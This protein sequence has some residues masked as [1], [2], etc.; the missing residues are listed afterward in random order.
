MEKKAEITE[1]VSEEILT[2]VPKPEEI[3]TKD[4]AE[5]EETIAKSVAEIPPTTDELEKRKKKLVRLFKTK[6]NWIYGVILAFLV[7]IAVF[8]RTRNLPRLRDVSTGTWTL[9]P[10]LDPFL[11]LRWAKYI[12]ANGSLMIIDTMRYS[13]LGY[14]TGSEMKLLSYLIVW[15][16]DFLAFFSKEA[17]VTYAAVLFPVVMFAL[18][19]IA[20]FLFARKIFYKETQKVRNIIALIATCF[21]ILIPSLLPRTIAGIPEK[22]SAAFFFLFMAFY[23]FLEAMTSKKMKTSVIWAILAGISTA[24]MALVWGG[25]IFVFFTIPTAFL[26]AFLFGKIDKQK[27]LVYSIW[28]FAAF[29]LMSPFSSR[30]VIKNLLQSTSTGLAIGVFVLVGISLIIVKKN[31]FKEMRRKTKLPKELF[32]LIVSIIILIIIALIIL[33]PSFFSHNLQDVKRSLISPQTTRWGL[34]V[35]ENKQP[36]FANDWKNSFGPIVLNVPLFFWMFIIGSV[37]LFNRLL[38]KLKP[39]ERIILTFS[40]F[41]FLIALIFSRYSASNI[42]NGTSGLSLIVYFGGWIFFL[43]VFGYFYYKNYQKGDFLVFKEFNFAYILYFIVLTLAIIGARGGIR[44]IM[45]LGAVSPIAIAFLVV[46][47]SQKYLKTKEETMKFFIGVLAIILILASLFTLWTYYKQ[48]KI[49]ATNFAPSAYQWQ[50]QKAMQ[51]VREETP[52]DSVFGHWWDYGYW[53]QSLGERATI[54][55]GSNS[56]VYW[57]HLMGRHVLTGTDEKTALE[58]LYTHKGTHLLIDSTDIGKYTA[59][60]SIGADENYDR[61]SW[62]STFLMDESQTQETNNQTIYVY[63]GGTAIDD[64]IIWELDGREILL[65]K[66]KAGIGAIFLTKT[67]EAIAQPEAIFVYNNNQYKIP[68][69]YAYYNGKLYDFD[70]GLD[71]GVFLYPRIKASSDGGIDLNEIGAAMYLSKRT[72]HSHLANLY[73]FNQESDYFKVAHS[74]NSYMVD[75]LRTQGLEIGEFVYYGGFQGPIKI[76]N[77]SYPSDIQENPAYLEQVFPNDELWQVKSGEY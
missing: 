40:Y 49:T 18:T 30:Y 76:W 4:V 33:G 66:K 10:D 36:Y 29:I 9:G 74:E 2:T 43:F 52:K 54:L 21:F 19:T 60:S 16:Y 65:P 67:E 75:G 1:D 50:W 48:D 11:F 41:I 31:L 72:V 26:L 53:I 35:A 44:L 69:K 25:M 23:L 51:W 39:K 13:P 22:E 55:D 59:F 63:S 32:S 17:T 56:I 6:T 14:R 46:K 8:I 42:L 62:I 58:F 73:L 34:T 27:F 5:K 12:A 28:M 71:A 70:S 3:V 38:A 77:I 47:T 15:F 57:N 7:Y 64:D 37:V 20:F 45:V 24:L 61:Y 68:L